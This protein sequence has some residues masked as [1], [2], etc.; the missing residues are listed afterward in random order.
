MGDACFPTCSDRP[1]NTCYSMEVLDLP[2]P[3]ICQLAGEGGDT[4]DEIQVQPPADDTTAS[5]PPPADTETDPVPDEPIVEDASKE[6]TKEPSPSDTAVR[7]T[8]AWLLVLGTLFA[9]TVV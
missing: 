3:E 7:P 9:V 2:N 4:T 1:D 5:P 8:N 6:A